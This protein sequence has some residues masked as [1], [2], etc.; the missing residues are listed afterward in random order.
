MEKISTF[1]N[2]ETICYHTRRLTKLEHSVR[3]NQANM[4][5]QIANYI[6]N[7][8]PSVLTD[9]E[10]IAIRH[11][12]SL[13]KLDNTN[14]DETDEQNERRTNMYKKQGW[15]SEDK[16]VLELLKDGFDQF[17]TNLVTRAINESADKIFFNNCSKCGKLA[18]TPQARQCKCGHNWHNIK[19][20][21]FKINDCFQIKKRSFFI[22][23]EILNGHVDIGNF[24]D[25]TFLELNIKPE[26]M[27]IEFLLKRN[28][29]KS[30]EN[31]AFGIT[32]LNE[33]QKEFLKSKLSSRPIHIL[34]QRY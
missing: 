25:L 33:E 12:Q 24:I 21:E 22:S 29:D 32:E 13:Q 14:K 11:I 26:I 8:F 30:I 2:P 9:K 3:K 27:A 6:I 23:G 5:N 28:K 7:Y 10:R 31:I 18:N 17:E 19:V 34:K 4:R 15:L 1:A 20:A 16:D